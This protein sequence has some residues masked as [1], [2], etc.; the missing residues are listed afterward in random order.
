LTK[1]AAG[2]AE[3]E[4]ESAADIPP[5]PVV[6]RDLLHRESEEAVQAVDSGADT[7][8]ANSAESAKS[9]ETSSAETNSNQPREMSE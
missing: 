7:P 8:S 3:G 1:E 9:A 6:D 4:H 5:Q 2:Q